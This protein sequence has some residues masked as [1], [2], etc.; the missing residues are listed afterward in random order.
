MN[1]DLLQSVEVPIGE[2][3]LTVERSDTDGQERIEG[4]VTAFGDWATLEMSHPPKADV[5]RAVSEKI[6]FEVTM[7]SAVVLEDMLQI[8]FQRVER[9]ER[10]GPE[11]EPAEAAPLPE[12]VPAEPQA[13]KPESNG[14]A[15]GNRLPKPAPSEE[16][17]ALARIQ[18]KRGEV[19]R[20]YRQAKLSKGKA[21]TD[22]SAW[23]DARD[24]LEELIEL[25]ETEPGLPLLKA[26][27]A[28]AAPTANGKAAAPNPDESW[29]AV[30]ITVLLDHGLTES[31]LKLLTDGETKNGERIAFTTIGQCTDWQAK[32]GQSGVTAPLTLIKGLGGAKLAKVDDAFTAFWGSRGRTE[33]AAASFIN[34]QL[35][36]ETR[37]MAECTAVGE[38]KPELRGGL[39]KPKRA[40]RKV[41]K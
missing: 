27:K 30:P 40:A 11:A 20:A 10:S 41:A 17:T 18:A 21:K 1:T 8:R 24:E 22:K 12:P 23:E 15:P 6:G 16:A 28:A 2:F 19:A 34:S 33:K 39:T 14:H 32:V 31:I 38:D 29:R 13:A 36:P 25:S 5:V 37:E 7:T 26:E 9:A 4:T 3:T 35:S